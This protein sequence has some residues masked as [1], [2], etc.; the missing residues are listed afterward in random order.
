VSQL[1]AERECEIVTEYRAIVDHD[2]LDEEGVDFD[3]YANQYTD[4]TPEDEQ[5]EEGLRDHLNQLDQY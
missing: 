3:E 5:T 2:K 1:T 4:F